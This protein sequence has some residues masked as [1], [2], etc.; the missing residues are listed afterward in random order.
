M[1]HWAA[2]AA[3]L[4]LAASAV[5]AWAAEETFARDLTVNG[6]VDLT[7]QTGSGSIHL[8]P[9]PG[10]H[11]HIIGHVRSSWSGNDDKVREIADHP[12]VEQTGN[13]VRVG[14]EHENLRN[15]SIDYE[16]EAPADAFLSAQSGSGNVVDDGVGADAKLGTGS[17]SI[18][19]TGL[20]GGPSLDTGS[21]NIY[22]ELTGDGDARAQTG[23][24]SIELHGV[25]GALR[26]ETGSGNIKIDGRPVGPWKLTTGSG[27]VELSTADSA[28]TLDAKT[29]SGSIH[30]DREML[31]QGTEEHHHL[32]GKIAGGGPL[33]RIETGSGSIRIH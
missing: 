27:G 16:I 4:A 17:G 15:I 30:S 14:V 11:V 8:T 20:Q 33:V 7:V 28:F 3:A 32:T 9:G 24:G 25:H 23:S 1:R 26:A 31:T 2:K 13:I 18:H 10:G 12:P 19:A 22:A 29:G 5:T 21:G 6:R